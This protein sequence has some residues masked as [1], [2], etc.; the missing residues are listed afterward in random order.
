MKYCI[1]G[2]WHLGCVMAAS[3]AQEG[4]QV[5][6]LDQDRE[7]I[8]NLQANRPPIF[9]PGLTELITQG[10]AAG[11]L[12]FTTDFSIALNEA[13]LLWVAFDTPV[14]EE[15][16]ADIGFVEKQLD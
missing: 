9:E 14:D 13:E 8:E 16:R 11:Q 4:F 6:G 3:L 1:Y 12:D 15:D 2:L 10:Q 5:V 7:V